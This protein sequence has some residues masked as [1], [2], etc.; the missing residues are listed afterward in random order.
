MP[1]EE[2]KHP[3]RWGGGVIEDRGRG[4]GYP[5]RRRGSTGTARTSA[6]RRGGAKYSFFGAEIPTKFQPYWEKTPFTKG[7]FSPYQ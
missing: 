5:R 7:C 1:E 4:G 6:R 2:S 3:S